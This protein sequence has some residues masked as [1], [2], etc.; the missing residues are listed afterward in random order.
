MADTSTSLL[1]LV[2]QETGNNNNSW[3]DIADANFLKLENAIA[4]VG[5]VAITG[6]TTVLTDDQARNAFLAISGTLTSDAIIQVPARTKKWTV[7]NST[8]GNY[9]VT[10]KTS[11]NPGYILA[12][13]QAEN[14]YCDSVNVRCQQEAGQVPVG[15]LVMMSVYTQPDG[16][17]QCS[18]GTASRVLYAKLYAIIG[19]TWGSG[20]G[21]TTFN[22]PNLDDRYPRG[23]GGYSVGATPAY[24]TA[25]HTHSVSGTTASNGGHSHSGTTYSSGSHDH[26]G[27]VFL[28]GASGNAL[29]GGGSP[30]YAATSTSSVNEDGT[31]THTFDTNSVGNHT[32]TFSATSGSTGGSET[33][34]NSSVVNFVIRYQ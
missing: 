25:A 14:I 1:Q 15:G 26:D 33:M 29:L 8:T 23:R 20:D 31:H 34:P 9:T 21:S 6:G 22:L 24:A 28:S 11:G 2:D 7:F 13:N 4:G 30:L 18:G 16:Y 3:G 27:E 12:R 10:V 17:L 5:S 32:H 19:T